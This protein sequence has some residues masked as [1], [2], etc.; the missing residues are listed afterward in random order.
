MLCPLAD[1]IAFFVFHRRLR[2]DVIA[3]IDLAD[4]IAKWQM[5]WPQGELCYLW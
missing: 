4:V 2:A 3:L 5:E 1:V